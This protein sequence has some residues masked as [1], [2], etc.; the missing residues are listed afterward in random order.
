MRK[1][2]SLASPQT[3]NWSLN[4]LQGQQGLYL[5]LADNRKD[6][7]ADCSPGDTEGIWI[8]EM[9]VLG[10]TES[11]HLS[12]AVSLYEVSAQD[13]SP[14]PLLDNPKYWLTTNEA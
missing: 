10:S 1:A 4:L 6:H 2:H 3:P 11:N 8:Q 13:T 12:R 5:L 14:G 9:P 7:L